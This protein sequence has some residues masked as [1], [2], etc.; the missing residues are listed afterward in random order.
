M[1]DYA[2]YIQHYWG[3]LM[4]NFSI[5]AIAATAST[6]LL[7]YTGGSAEAFITWLVMSMLDTIL[8]LYRAVLLGTFSA[9]K[10]HRWTMRIGTQLVIVFLI[11]AVTY[12]LPIAND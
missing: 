9:R 12:N 3:Q 6:L 11:A 10:L 4:D 5:C 7:D 2:A 8:G 1:S